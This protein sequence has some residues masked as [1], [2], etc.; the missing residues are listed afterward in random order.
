M[1]I[2]SNYSDTLP[3]GSIIP[4]VGENYLYISHLGENLEYWFLPACPD[5]IQ[6]SMEST[7]NS[8]NVL[9][10]SAPVFTYS[11]SGGR[12]VQVTLKLH[13]DIMDDI[14]INRSNVSLKTEY[15]EDY[16]DALCRAVQAIALPRYNLDNKA[17]EPPLVAVRF[18]DQ[19]FI[20]GIV[21]GAV[22][23]TYEKPIILTR[24]GKQSKYACVT[25]SFDVSEVDP[26]DATTVYQNGSF[27]G[28]VKTLKYGMNLGDD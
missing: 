23:V 5:S 10:R 24:D 19:I 6:D 11:N 17:V 9:G 2:E 15:G 20:K 7:F 16:V 3:S 18:G 4:D 21:N 12:K 14:N 28:V 26:Y 13:R 1:G 27:R 22:G 8:T 25:I